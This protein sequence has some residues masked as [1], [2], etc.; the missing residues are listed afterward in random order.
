MRAGGRRGDGSQTDRE[1]SI[2]PKTGGRGNR[3]ECLERRG[4]AGG[5]MPEAA[6]G[7]ALPACES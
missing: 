5:F 1:E 3:M 7:Y 4:G 2:M 6:M